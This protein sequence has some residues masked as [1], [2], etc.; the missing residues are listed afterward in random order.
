[1]CCSSVVLNRHKHTTSDRLFV[2]A[3]E[4]NPGTNNLWVPQVYGCTEPRVLCPL[5]WNRIYAACLGRNA[6]CTLSS[7]HFLVLPGFRKS[8]SRFY[9][10]R[11]N[12][13]PKPLRILHTVSAVLPQFI[14]GIHTKPRK[15]QEKAPHR[16]NI[17]VVPSSDLHMFT[18]TS[19]N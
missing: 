4:R 15:P 7:S 11:F 1:M 6:D 13:K 18:G 17:E 12:S 2:V 3:L 16:T 14:H 10:Q 19:T 5:S 9:L 8:L